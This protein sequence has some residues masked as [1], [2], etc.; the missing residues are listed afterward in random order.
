MGNAEDEGGDKDDAQEMAALEK[1]LNRMAKAEN[2]PVFVRELLKETLSHR[3]RWPSWAE[4]TLDIIPD[5]ARAVKILDVKAGKADRSN[6][7]KAVKKIAY[8]VAGAH[9]EFG[10]DTGSGN[11]FFSRLLG[12]IKAGGK[13]EDFMNIS[14][15]E[16]E[17]LRA[18][19][20]A[21]HADDDV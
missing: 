16:E 20:A 11:G 1:I 19:A 8:Q 14:P 6:F 3:D 13:T 10:D 4:D 21:L 9:G 15:G 7:K 17:A 12:K 2:V 18:L 5:C